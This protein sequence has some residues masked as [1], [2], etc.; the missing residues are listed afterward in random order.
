[1]SVFLQ[2]PTPVR[3]HGL[4]I[5]LENRRENNGILGGQTAL[6][7]ELKRFHGVQQRFK[8]RLAETPCCV[9]Y[10]FNNQN[11]LKKALFYL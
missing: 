7:E 11:R 4:E 2:A 8:Q 9:K 10:F 5:R 1:V 6:K 3:S